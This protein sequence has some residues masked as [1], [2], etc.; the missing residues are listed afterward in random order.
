MKVKTFWLILLKVI[1]FFLVLNGVN[2]LMQSFAMLSAVN[3]MSKDNL[4]GF[5]LIVILTILIYL[6][7]LW[8]FVFKTSWLID[9]LHL[10]RGFE[11]E[12][13]ETNIELTNI[14]SV[15][16]IVIGGMLLIQ[17]LPR[18]CQQIFTFFQMKSMNIEQESQTKGWII[19]YFIQ[20]CLGYLLMTNSNRITNFINKRASSDS[21]DE[22]KQSE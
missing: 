21:T 5:A 22:N 2:L 12:K 6:F 19:L 11:D 8:L 9:K 14:L 16:I 10:A 17:S 7:V 1:G 20:V 13:V 4:L 18:L 3:T 15:A